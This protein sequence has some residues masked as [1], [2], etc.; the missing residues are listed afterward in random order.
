MIEMIAHWATMPAPVAGMCLL[1]HLARHVVRFPTRVES[2][3]KA[4]S[5]GIGARLPESCI[6]LSDGGEGRG[7]KG[8]SW[9]CVS[10]G[11]IGYELAPNLPWCQNEGRR[12]WYLA[13]EQVLIRRR[14]ILPY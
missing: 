1:P 11:T 14:T 13:V 2:R 7:G 12:S 4:G 3:A 9:A 10:N 8:E 6:V 5:D